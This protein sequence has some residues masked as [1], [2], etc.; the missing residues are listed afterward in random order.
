MIINYIYGFKE[1]EVLYGFK[2]KK[3]YRLP[4]MIGLRFYPLKE[5]PLRIEIIGKSKWK[6]YLLRGKRKSLKQIESMTVFINHV[7]EEIKHSD[8]PF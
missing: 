8:C 6:G 4:Q 3:L 2:E 5:V 1:N 7:V